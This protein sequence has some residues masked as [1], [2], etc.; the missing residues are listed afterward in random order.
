MTTTCK[1]CN[2]QF[3]GHFCNNC[4]QTAETHKMNFHF[5]L[6]DMQH[7][8]FH[9]DSGILYTAKQLFTRPGN[10]IR[11]FIIGKRVRHFKPISLVI[12]LATVYGFLYHIFQIRMTDLL[13]V[14]S[15]SENLINIGKINDWIKN[16]YAWVS[17]LT[18]PFYT[19]GTFIAFKKQG[20]NFVEHFVLNAFLAGQRL[21]F[22]IATFPFIYIFNGTPTIKIITGLISIIDFMLI[23]WGYSQFFNKL[24][25]LKSFLLTILSYLIFVLTII[26]VVGL[27]GG[28]VYYFLTQH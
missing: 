8:L 6:H 15:S 11:D 22:H 28:V 14:T 7:G 18:L 20:Y 4:G 10:A 5:L 16:H 27:V 26:I 2:Q 21:I 24:S 25:K 9:F 17:L 13:Q 12:L 3:K 23:L 1:N 19:F